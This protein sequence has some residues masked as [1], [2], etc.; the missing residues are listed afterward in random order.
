MMTDDATPMEP[1]PLT[2]RTDLDGLFT[3]YRQ[4]DGTF[5]AEYGRVTAPKELSLRWKLQPSEGDLAMALLFISQRIET[6]IP[7]A[8]IPAPRFGLFGASNLAEVHQ[9]ATTTKNHADFFRLA[10]SKFSSSIGAELEILLESSSPQE[11]KNKAM[12]G[13]KKKVANALTALSA[14]SER[15]AHGSTASAT[16]TLDDGNVR[17]ATLAW[18]VLETARQLVAQRQRLPAKGEI[19][20]TIGERFP[21][22]RGLGK[23]KWR[24]TWKECGLSQLEQGDPWEFEERKKAVR[25]KTKKLPRTKKP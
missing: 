24:N 16:V 12:A 15:V 25:A 19:Q 8:E 5:L 11:A 23:T 1:P 2:E 4:T 18:I 9:I 10:L 17:Q 20:V 22:L 13:V 14:R 7:T 21:E 3:L 6:A